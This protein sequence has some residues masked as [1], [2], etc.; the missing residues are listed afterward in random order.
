MQTFK[1]FIKEEE[2][3][4]HPFHSTLLKHG[5]EKDEKLSKYWGSAIQ[6]NSIYSKKTS[7]TVNIKSRGTS[8][9]VDSKGHHKIL[10]SSTNIPTNI[11]NYVRFVGKDDPRW[12]HYEG[13]IGSKNSKMK[14]GE[15]EKSLDKFLTKKHPLKESYLTKKLIESLD[16]HKLFNKYGWKPVYIHKTHKLGNKT[17]INTKT[18]YKHPQGHV[19]WIM[20]RGSW[21]IKPKEGNNMGSETNHDL[22]YTLS[23]LDKNPPNINESTNPFHKTLIKHGFSLN[24]SETHPIGTGK[25][26]TYTHPIGDTVLADHIGN[27]KMWTHEGFG[28]KSGHSAKSLEH[29][30]ASVSGF[31]NVR[32]SVEHPEENPFHSTLLKHGFEHT[33]SKPGHY[34]NSEWHEYK[35][36]E[37]GGIHVAIYPKNHGMGETHWRHSHPNTNGIG[38]RGG[39]ISSS[40]GKT[41]KALNDY[42][43]HSDGKNTKIRGVH[44][45]SW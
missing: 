19:A 5:Y 38:V 22:S 1:Q 45:V 44:T 4:E 7:G 8:A 20:K 23:Q 10:Y 15:G 28:N 12:Q 31:R 39:P 33:D 14:S 34:N 27:E 11:D 18:Y 29:R 30:L 17:P 42:L 25:R 3:K 21:K 35:H 9:Q 13:S 37:K 26:D 32:E 43:S 2:N 41:A 36:P 24:K 6:P 16:G 40:A